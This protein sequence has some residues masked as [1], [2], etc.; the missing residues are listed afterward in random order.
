MSTSL[1]VV[2]VGDDGIGKTSM[3]ITYACDEVPSNYIPTVFDNYTEIITLDDRTVSLSLWDTLGQDGYDRLRPLGYTETD[4]FLLCF[5]IASPES[6]E[7]C[8]TKWHPEITHSCPSAHVILVGL[9]EDLRE[10]A[11]TVSKLNENGK[12]PVTREEGERLCK[13]LGCVEYLECSIKNRK[14]VKDLISESVKVG[15]GISDKSGRGYC[16]LQ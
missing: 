16:I 7:R 1:K 6:F 13:K 5:S 9:E 11:G 4:V 14:E 8:R 2:V 12:H 15:L 10:D 3:L